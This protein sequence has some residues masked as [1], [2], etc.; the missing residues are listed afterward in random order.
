MNGKTKRRTRCIETHRLRLLLTVAARQESGE[1]IPGINWFAACAE[2]TVRELIY[3]GLLTNGRNIRLTPSGRRLI[4]ERIHTKQRKR[5]KSQ[6]GTYE[7]AQRQP[8]KPHDGTIYA[9]NAP[10]PS[11][12]QYPKRDMIWRCQGTLDRFIEQFNFDKLMEHAARHR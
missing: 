5:Q 8:H 12:G 9:P 2:Q 4:A 7:K 3:D 6:V 11:P 1:P 10:Q